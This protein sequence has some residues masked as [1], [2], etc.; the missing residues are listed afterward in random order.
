[1]KLFNNL[2]WIP[3]F[4]QAK[5]T[6]CSIIYKRLQGHA[7]TYLKSLVKLTTSGTHS[8]QT[9][10]ANFNI[11]RPIIKR[12]TEGGR[13]FTVAA[14]QAWN[15]SFVTAINAEKASLKSFSNSLRKKIFSGTET[16]KSFHSVISVSLAFLFV[17]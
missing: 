8:R 16:F 15:T 9:R 13:I 14:C 2:N 10:Y 4:E 1:M 5:L 17:I 3:F 7:P 12:K 6:K 11:S